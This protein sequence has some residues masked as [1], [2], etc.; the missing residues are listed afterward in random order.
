MRRDFASR[1]GW[2]TLPWGATALSPAVAD[3]G[4]LVPFGNLAALPTYRR[5]EGP[6]GGER[7]FLSLD[8]PHS[9][10]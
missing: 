4:G 5:R 2:R 3:R 8:K 7:D 10:G 1:I 6:I 9:I